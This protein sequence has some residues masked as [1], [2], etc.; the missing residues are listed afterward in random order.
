MKNIVVWIVLIATSI[1][2]HTGDQRPDRVTWD[3]G[4]IDTPKKAKNK[5]NYISSGKRILIKRKDLWDS[6]V[7]DPELYQMCHFVSSNDPDALL[8]RDKNGRGF[9]VKSIKKITPQWYTSEEY[10]NTQYIIVDSTMS[11]EDWDMV[12]SD[13][14]D[15]A[16]DQYQPVKQQQSQSRASRW[17]N[18][19]F[20]SK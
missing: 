5:P 18:Y 16:S 15:Q 19:L 12:Y 1:L 2:I 4:V 7:N 11:Y 6:R 9:F 8:F 10:L 17:W 13:E 14:V 20:P 3:Q